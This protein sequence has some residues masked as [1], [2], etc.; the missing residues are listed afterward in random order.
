MSSIQ[1]A[2][3]DATKHPLILAAG[4][5]GV[6]AAAL[7]VMVRGG[8]SQ[9]LDTGATAADPNAANTAGA[10]DV[11]PGQAPPATDL[12]YLGG[13]G[14]DPYSSSTY[15]NIDPTTGLPYGYTPPATDP[16]DCST[17]AQPTYAV[18]GY[19]WECVSGAWAFLPDGTPTPGPIP[20]PVPPVNPKGCPLPKPSIPPSLIGRARYVC[21]RGAWVL[22]STKVKPGPV[23]TPGPVKPPVVKPNV[24]RG[25]HT[26]YAGH[27]N[28]RG[29]LVLSDGRTVAVN[30]AG[31]WTLGAVEKG[32]AQP[33]KKSALVRV[34]LIHAAPGN[35]GQAGRYLKV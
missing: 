4:V 23:P 26:T 30:P 8:G 27:K 35:G 16:G 21:K 3:K 20:P 7:L 9:P 34:R 15:P 2:L 12:S 11:L 31:H 25:R 29:V 32:D 1:D 24:S 18:A 28:A 19:H 10:S 6:S 14:S 33:Y 17:I 5:V 22:E 13:L